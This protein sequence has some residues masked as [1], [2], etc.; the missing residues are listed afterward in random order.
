MFCSF[1]V[2]NDTFSISKLSGSQS[3]EEAGG[4]LRHE[5]GSGTFVVGPALELKLQTML[6]F[7]LLKE[8]SQD[9]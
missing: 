8:E 5:K 9:F 6:F 2:S 1:S 7:R 3:R 4:G